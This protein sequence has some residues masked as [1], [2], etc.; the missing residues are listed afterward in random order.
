MLDALRKT[1][2]AEGARGL[3]RGFVPGVWGVSHGALQFMAYE[4]L[5]SRYNRHHHRPVDHALCTAEYLQFAALSKLFAACVTYPYQVRGRAAGSA[6]KSILGT[7]NSRG[8]GMTFHETPKWEANV[9]Q[10]RNYGNMNGMFV[11]I[12][13][14]SNCLPILR[15]NR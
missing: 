9:R 4:E 12:Q 11:A 6:A 3:Y 5:K 14:W 7:R 2:R 15:S 13:R 10:C 8:H 1:Y